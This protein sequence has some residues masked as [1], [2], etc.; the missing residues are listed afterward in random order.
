MPNGIDQRGELRL[1]KVASAGFEP[2]T[3]G[4]DK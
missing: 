1:K 4:S 2:V 3:D